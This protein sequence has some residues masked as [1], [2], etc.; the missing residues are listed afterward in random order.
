MASSS[1]PAPGPSSN[2]VQRKPRTIILCFDGTSNEYDAAVR[3][4]SLLGILERYNI[5]Y[6]IRMW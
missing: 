4:P 1:T 5:V 3:Q 6:R 2:K